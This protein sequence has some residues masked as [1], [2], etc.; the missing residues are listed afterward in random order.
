MLADIHTESLAELL[1]QV[2]PKQAASNGFHIFGSSLG[3]GDT[4]EIQGG[5]SSGK[6]HLLFHLIIDCIIPFQ[7]AGCADV[8]IVFDM[9]HS[10]DI[11]R[12][13]HLLL[14]RLTHSVGLDT[15]AAEFVA[16]QSLKRL[17]IFRPTSTLQ[18]AATFSHL[19]TYHSSQ[20][21]GEKIGIV[22]IDSM[23]SRYW[24]DRFIAEQVRNSFT[25]HIQPGSKHVPP[26]Q[27]VLLALESFS[28]IHRPLVIMTNWGLH[29]LDNGVASLYRQH[30]QPLPTLSSLPAQPDRIAKINIRHP[31]SENMLKLTVHV[32]LQN[33]DANTWCSSSETQD[34]SAQFLVLL[35][36]PNSSSV[37]KFILSISDEDTSLVD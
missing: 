7:H 35:R 21:S 24:P 22:A 28:R 9:D 3:R 10:F 15:S 16:Q 18:L 33:I 32:T 25:S 8:A 30:L 20:F 1:A 34:G 19:A 17:H 5:P 36:K 29:S 31:Y 27:H 23:S 11:I 13:N 14:R 2:H 4:L 6:T 26:L 37:G 12:L